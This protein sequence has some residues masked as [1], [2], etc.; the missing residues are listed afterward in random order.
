M[1]RLDETET[2]EVLHLNS[3][4]SHQTYDCFVVR[5]T[6][7]G[8]MHLDCW[9]NRRHHE[10][11]KAAVGWKSWC[12]FVMIVQLTHGLRITWITFNW[13]IHS[14]CPHEKSSWIC[15]T[16][17]LRL[18]WGPKNCAN[19]AANVDMLKYW[20]S[21]IWL[22]YGFTI[23]CGDHRNLA[24]F[25]QNSIHTTAVRQRQW[26]CKIGFS[27]IVSYTNTVPTNNCSFHIIKFVH[28]LPSGFQ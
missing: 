4:C 2:A 18:S 26:W 15:L 21:T 8:Q 17:V 7:G 10:R 11:R 24:I 23:S 19:I 3:A 12:Y 13:Q 16:A 6:V 22:P 20:S 5:F 9:R 28:H 1:Y 27:L 14:G 25:F